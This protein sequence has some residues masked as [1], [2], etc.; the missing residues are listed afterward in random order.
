LRAR[1]SA[2]QRFLAV[3]YSVAFADDM[4]FIFERLNAAADFVAPGDPAFARYLR[5]RARD[6]LADDYEGGDAAW[7]TS[8]F[9]GNL[10][11]Q[12]GAY[13]T[14]DDALYGVKTMF[15]LS[16]L[17]RDA[18]RS[19]ELAAA[20][21]GIQAVENALPYAT[22]RQVRSDIPVNVYNIIADFGQARGGNT[23]TILPNESY[24]A[25]QYGRTILI[26]GNILRSP[27]RFTNQNETFN[28]A[29][30]PAHH[31]DLTADGGFYRTLWHEVGHYLGVDR[32]ADGREL[33]DALE[34]AA[35]LFEEMKADLVSLTAARILHAQGR[36]TDAELRAIYASGILR[37]LQRNRPRR[38]QPYQTMQLIQWNWFIDHG[39]LNFHDG[40]FAIDYA[41]YPEAVETLLRQVLALQLAGDR[42]AANA[43]VERWTNWDP[44]IHE[45][46]AANMR[47]AARYRYSLI[48]YEA[49]DGPQP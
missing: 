30:A 41:R 7:V 40:H 37:V 23:A 42:A 46:A 16:V 19:E 24:L 6:L 2:S 4:L 10:N 33:D 9:S 21:D 11:A 17:Q 20:M 3:P 49:L 28:A 15:S 35:S 25:R 44:A 14:Y 31:G 27:A 26:R 48:T 5:L 22:H 8:R 39:V 47:A 32:A 34:D 1:I 13:E 12:I 43:F 36:Y 29:I 38:E 18:P 45:I